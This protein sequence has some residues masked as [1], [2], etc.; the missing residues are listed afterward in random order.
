MSF[1]SIQLL[2]IHSLLLLKFK[3]SYSSVIIVTNTCIHTLINMFCLVDFSIAYTSMCSGPTA[4]YWLI[5]HRP[6]STSVVMGPVVIQHSVLLTGFWSQSPLPL[7]SAHTAFS[8]GSVSPPVWWWPP[9]VRHSPDFSFPAHL[10][11]LSIHS[12]LSLSC[13][14]LSTGLCVLQP[15]LALCPYVRSAPD[16]AGIQWIH[17]WIDEERN[18][19]AQWSTSFP[20]TWR[21]LSSFSTRKKNQDSRRIKDIVIHLLFMY[22]CPEYHS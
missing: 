2:Y 19:V 15:V 11:A 1:P 8:F 6:W 18:W 21:T 12:V 22:H 16:S 20:L 4:W 14:R 10:C 13:L 9:A 17:A 3:V 5:H 7:P